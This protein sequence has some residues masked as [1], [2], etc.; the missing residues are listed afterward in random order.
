MKNIGYRISESLEIVGKR[1]RNIE[2]SVEKG[3][4]SDYRKT[5]RIFS[6]LTKAKVNRT[7]FIPASL[8]NLLSNEHEAH[9]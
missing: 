8:P 1:I 6:V 4:I 3:Q 7:F 5:S 2:I 9:R